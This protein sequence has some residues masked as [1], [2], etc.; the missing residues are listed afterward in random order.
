MVKLKTVLNNFQF[1]IYKISKNSTCLA[2]IARYIYYFI[3][4][5]TQQSSYNILFINK[6]FH[7]LCNH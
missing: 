6:L 3:S 2:V 7:A 4:V 5:E 1:F